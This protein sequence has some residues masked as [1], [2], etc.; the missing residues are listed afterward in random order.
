MF[1]E[2]YFFFTDLFYKIN[3]V[4]L[5]P[6]VSDPSVFVVPSICT[7]TPFSTVSWI[8]FLKRR[9]FLTKF[10]TRPI[11]IEYPVVVKSPSQ[12]DTLLNAVKPKYLFVE[13]SNSDSALKANLDS[14]KI[15]PPPLRQTYLFGFVVFGWSTRTWNN[16]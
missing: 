1:I 3:M 6:T 15:S 13:K 5:K 7:K 10:G 12:T 8:F 2:F 11:L 9:R 4:N 14:F 16:G